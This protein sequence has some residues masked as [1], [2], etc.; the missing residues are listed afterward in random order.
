MQPTLN[1]FP[2]ERD[3]QSAQAALKRLEPIVSGTSRRRPQGPELIADVTLELRAGSAKEPVTLTLP[4][5]VLRALA[6]MLAEVAKGNAVTV[7]PVHAEFTTQEA[8]DFLNVSRPFLI[9]LLEENAIPFRKVRSHRRIRFGDL[10]AYKEKD[11]RKREQ[12]LAELAEDAHVNN[13]GY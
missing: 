1:P 9:S 3:S 11:D 13:H 4:W 5:E 6:Q 8:A 7:V 12:V 2:S 10:A